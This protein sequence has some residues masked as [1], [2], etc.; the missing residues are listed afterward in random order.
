[1]PKKGDKK[2]WPFQETTDARGL[3]VLMHAYL[4][5]VG[6]RGYSESALRNAE[7]S[8]SAFIVF[9]HERALVK[10]AE[11]TKPVLERYQRHL[12]NLRKADGQPLS[13]VH[14]HSQLTYI[15][16]FFRWLSRQ[17][18]ILSNPASEIELPKLPIR[19]PRNILSVEEVE[20][21]LAIPDLTNPLGLR[22]RAILETFY[23]TGLRRRELAH[24]SLYDI[25]FTRGTL[26][27]RQG[28]GRKD[29]VVPIGERALAWIEKYLA[30]V[31]PQLAVEPDDG[32][33][34]LA[35]KGGPFN[36]DVLTA[37]VRGY[38]D[39]SEVGKKGSCHLFRH[40]TATLM[41]EGGAD[42]RYVQEMLGHAGLNTTQIYTRVSIAKLKE[43]HTATHPGARLKRTKQ[44]EEGPEGRG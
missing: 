19:L 32:S 1:V 35:V 10:A 15:K 25:D 44:S 42:V 39:A 40:A 6:A 5:A 27:V 8:L 3:V 29:R 14:Q 11:V 16:L 36:P 26:M 13:I 24:L 37:M 43:I 7:W 17:N 12:F 9:C 2:L 23:S 31:R 20:R 33:L 41:L 38:V 28:K 22:D 4:E 34:F 21:I 18:F 30:D